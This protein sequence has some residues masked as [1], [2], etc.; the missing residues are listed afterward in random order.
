MNKPDLYNNDL[1]SAHLPRLT[2]SHGETW[3]EVRLSYLAG[4]PGGAEFVVDVD[5]TGATLKVWNPYRHEWASLQLPGHGDSRKPPVETGDRVITADQRYE[6]L[7]L[8]ERLEA[9]SGGRKFN[10]TFA[11]YTDRIREILD[12]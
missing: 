4:G 5:E 2:G 6:A 1:L 11:S 12:V 7:D 8:L 3:Q 9:M 10:A